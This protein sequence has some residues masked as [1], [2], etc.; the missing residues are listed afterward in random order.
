M[1]ATPDGFPL[2]PDPEF[3]DNVLV[4]AHIAFFEIVEKSSAL[5]N[6]FEQSAPGV[7]I[8]LMGLEVIVQRRNSVRQE[9][10]LDLRG[11]RVVIVESEPINDFSFG[12][13]RKDHFHT[14][15][16]NVGW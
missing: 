11:S 12:C 14:S 2:L 1:I 6:E 15:F 13:C 7:M 16:W 10:D 4:S 5:P 3:F 8:L 9:G